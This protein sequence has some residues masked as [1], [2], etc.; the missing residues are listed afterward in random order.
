MEREIELD[1][2]GFVPPRTSAQ[3]PPPVPG[4]A[5][6]HLPIIA[7]LAVVWSALGVF[8]F[9]AALTRYAPYL[10][11]LSETARSGM[12]ELPLVGYG[13][14]AIAAFTAL[15]GS[16]MLFRRQLVAVRLL[17]VA[18]TGTIITTAI[19]NLPVDGAPQEERVYAALMIVIA[20][21]L[22]YYAFIAAK[23]GVLR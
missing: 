13:L 7:G 12:T 2:A 10:E 20:L 1:D 9:M 14:W 19:R 4:H 22:L 18:A 6:W 16:V 15:A 21:L 11:M 8:E 3:E 5:T 23:R 17:A